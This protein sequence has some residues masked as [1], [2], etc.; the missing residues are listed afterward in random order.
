VPKPSRSSRSRMRTRRVVS[1][2]PPPAGASTPDAPSVP[3]E[4]A[5]AP[6]APAAAPRVTRRTQA[7]LSAAVSQ[8]SFTD[9]TYVI[10]E[11]KRIFVISGV[12]IALML[13]LWLFIR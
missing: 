12:I 4:A 13:V 7:G 2:T 6:T 8:R 9:Y 3:A 5:A 11:L 1:A 10:N